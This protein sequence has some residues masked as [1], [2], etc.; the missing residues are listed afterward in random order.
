MTYSKIWFATGWRLL[1]ALV[2][3]VVVTGCGEQ[4]FLAPDAPG[5]SLPAL[6]GGD[7]V[8]LDEFRGSVVYVSFWASWCV[9]CREEMPHLQQL[10]EQYRADGFQ[11]IGINVDEDPAAARRFATDHGIGFPLVTDG[12][13][14]VSK[15]YRVAGYPSHYV[16]DRRGKVRFSALGFTEDDAL[17]V[18]QEV[19]TLLA[20]SI[21]AAN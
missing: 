12:D 16:V 5:F 17:A 20:E 7:S 15:L 10:W 3:T 19:R 4:R 11:V 6:E 13:R 8:S 21:D 1:A 14:A 18:T 2:F 9:P